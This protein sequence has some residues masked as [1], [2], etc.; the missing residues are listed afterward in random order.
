MI[1]LCDKACAQARAR[2]SKRITASHLK[3]AVIATDQF[4]FLTEIVSKVPDAPTAA[5]AGDSNGNGSDNSDEGAAA[6]A[7]PPKKKQRKPRAPRK[8]KTQE[9]E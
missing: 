5:A 6:A 9:E 7:D 8:S 2:S 1:S 4:D 3:Q